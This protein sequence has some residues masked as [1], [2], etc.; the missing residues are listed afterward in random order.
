MFFLVPLWIHL[1]YLDE[2]FPSVMQIQV[3]GAVL[4]TTNLLLPLVYV[5]AV[6]VVDFSLDVTEGVAVAARDVS[7]RVAR[8]RL[9]RRG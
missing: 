1:A 3:D 8:W 2:G 7:R 9:Q 4:E 6:L 5:A